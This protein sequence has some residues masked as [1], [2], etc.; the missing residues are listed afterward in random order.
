MESKGLF[1]LLFVNINTSVCEEM[2]SIP[3]INITLPNLNLSEFM[4]RVH[5][6]KKELYGIHPKELDGDSYP[7]PEGSTLNQTIDSSDG[8]KKHVVITQVLCL[9]FVANLDC[10]EIN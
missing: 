1:I 3:E 4:S 9:L 6:V 5:Q 2:E 8:L 10:I 7:P